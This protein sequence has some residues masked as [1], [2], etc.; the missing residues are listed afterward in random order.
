M[1]MLKIKKILLIAVLFSTG[2][3]GCTIEGE[4]IEACEKICETNGGID[5]LMAQVFTAPPICECVNGL[6]KQI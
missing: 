2:L 4:A 3:V 5:H 1:K 6:S